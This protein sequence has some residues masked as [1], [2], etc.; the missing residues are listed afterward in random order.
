[1]IAF[2]VI[3]II[4]REVFTKVF[5]KTFE[6]IVI[7]KSLLTIFSLGFPFLAARIILSSF[8]QGLGMGFKA[9]FLNLAQMILFS[10]PLALL[11]SA[12]VGLEGVWAGIV[13]GNVMSSFIGFF[14][15]VRTNRGIAQSQVIKGL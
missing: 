4:G 12:L 6:I 15:A 9:L 13:L 14:W 2:A 7:G 1:M 10:I 11:L 5:T 3:M 8:F